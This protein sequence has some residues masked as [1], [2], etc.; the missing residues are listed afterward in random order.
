MV[1]SRSGRFEK[2]EFKGKLMEKLSEKRFESERAKEKRENRK[3]E[4]REREFG[5]F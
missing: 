2:N 1:K 3:V 4:E 5:G